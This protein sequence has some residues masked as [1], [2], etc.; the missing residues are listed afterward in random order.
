MQFI[1]GKTTSIYQIAHHMVLKGKK[2]LLIDLDPQCSLSE[3]CVREYNGLDQLKPNECLN[4]VYDMWFQL[5]EY[6]N[7]EYKFNRDTLIKSIDENLEFI[8]SNIFYEKGGLDELA[9]NMKN[10]LEDLVVLQQFFQKHNIDKEY[11]YILLDCPPS[12]N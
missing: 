8:P 9:M 3:I 5:K 11:D 7:I 4:Y 12:N 10:D 2:V 6:P 1:L